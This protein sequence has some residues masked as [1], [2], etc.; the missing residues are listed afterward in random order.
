[1]LIPVHPNYQTLFHRAKV[2]ERRLI[3]EQMNSITSKPVPT[4]TL[5]YF[6]FVFLHF[7]K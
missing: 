5:Y 3:A 6:P 2:L 4:Q 7:T 1:M